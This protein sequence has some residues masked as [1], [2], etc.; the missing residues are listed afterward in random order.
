MWPIV[1]W[2]HLLFH[3]D[4][5]SSFSSRRKV[6]FYD[7]SVLDQQQKEPMVASTFI[8]TICINLLCPSNSGTTTAWALKRKV[9]DLKGFHS[10]GKIKIALSKNKVYTILL[11]SPD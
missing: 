11:G 9:G 8:A 6:F 5:D 2:V 3:P 10:K 7:H 4:E 1:T